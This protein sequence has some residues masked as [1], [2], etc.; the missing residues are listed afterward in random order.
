MH[1]GRL[2]TRSIPIGYIEKALLCTHADRATKSSSNAHARQSAKRAYAE[3]TAKLNKDRQDS[4][5]NDSGASNRRE[6]GTKQLLILY[7][8]FVEA[9]WLLDQSPIAGTIP[10]GNNPRC[11]ALYTAGVACCDTI[12]SSLPPSLWRTGLSLFPL[13]YKASLSLSS[14]R[15]VAILTMAL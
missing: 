9:S 5:D 1:C 12:E 3:I 14:Q 11:D 2:R 13:V 4:G 15:L 6:F 7:G 8:I 10:L